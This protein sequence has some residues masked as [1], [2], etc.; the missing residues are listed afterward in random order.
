L[1]ASFRLDIPP[2]VAERI[3]GLPAEVKHGVKEALRLLARDPGVGQPLLRELEGYWK[4]RVRR[5]R[6]V[7]Q[8]ARR[9]VRIV[10]V[11][12]RR[13]IYEEFGE[14]LGPRSR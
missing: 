2:H 7:Y 13:T 8:P 1:K 5:Y 14:R 10:A 9:V 4:Y 11:G 12:H 6:V 3:R